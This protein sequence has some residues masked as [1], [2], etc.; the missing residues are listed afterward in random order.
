MIIVSSILWGT[1]L[2]YTQYV[3]DNGMESKDMVSL[4]MLFGF[5]T[6]LIYILIKDK[7]LFKIDKRD[8]LFCYN[9]IYMS[10]PI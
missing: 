8:I 7:G 3:L 1:A 4:K 6:I 10:C 9:R 5:I 2:L